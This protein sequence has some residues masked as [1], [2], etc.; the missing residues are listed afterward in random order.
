M[1]KEMDECYKGDLEIS[2]LFN[3]SNVSFGFVNNGRPSSLC[4]LTAVI[5]FYCLYLL[6]KGNR[7]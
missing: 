4:C 3:A 1:A 6:S 5:S 7:E 2:F